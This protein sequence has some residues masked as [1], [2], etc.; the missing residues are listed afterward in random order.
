MS[1]CPK[2]CKSEIC[3][4]LQGAPGPWMSMNDRKEEAEKPLENQHQLERMGEIQ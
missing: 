2:C 1:L 4:G 3:Q